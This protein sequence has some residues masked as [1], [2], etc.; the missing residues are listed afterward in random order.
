MYIERCKHGLGRGIS[1]P[2][3]E[4]LQGDFSL[5]YQVVGSAAI[6]AGTNLIEQA[7][8]DE[9]FSLSS[10]AIDTIAGGIT[11]KLGGKGASFGKKG[12]YSAEALMKKNIGR[13]FKY[14]SKYGV[15][16]VWGG[17]KGAVK[18]DYLGKRMVRETYSQIVPKGFK[19]WGSSIAKEVGW[20]FTKS[21]ANSYVNH[22]SK[23]IDRDCLRSW[24]RDYD[25]MWQ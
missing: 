13:S 22:V 5:L 20:N 12:L 11:G 3:I 8:D 9:E 7:T 19:Q 4:I 24:K 2:T 16:S 17:I 6:S 15:K 18:N 10:L 21:A 25:R 23:R 1:K 14:N